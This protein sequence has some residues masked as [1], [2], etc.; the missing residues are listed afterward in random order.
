MLLEFGGRSPEAAELVFGFKE[1]LT[2]KYG[3]VKEGWIKCLD[4]AKVGRVGKEAFM[5]AC[6]TLGGG[7]DPE[8]LFALIEMQKHR[9]KRTLH[10]EESGWRALTRQGLLRLDLLRVLWRHDPVLWE[11]DPTRTLSRADE[12]ALRDIGLKPLVLL[13]C[14]FGVLQDVS[15][16]S[17]P[18][19]RGADAGATELASAVSSPPSVPARTVRASPLLSPKGQ[20]SVFVPCL[21]EPVWDEQVER[22]LSEI[23][24]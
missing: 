23:Y 16:S 5:S 10:Q 18:Q 6:A 15:W 20:A 13:L 21:L 22:R 24:V 14:H 9:G 4:K 7:W 12:A 17:P 1:A 8:K 2:E 3:S 19:Q 11:Q